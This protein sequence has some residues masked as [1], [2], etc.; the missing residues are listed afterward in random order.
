MKKRLEDC[1]AAWFVCK[2]NLLDRVTVAATSESSSF[3]FM[4]NIKKRGFSEEK[5]AECFEIWGLL[6]R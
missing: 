2:S 4:R 3:E 6:I 1:G 5:K